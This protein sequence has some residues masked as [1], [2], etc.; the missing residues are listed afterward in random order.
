MISKLYKFTRQCLILF[1]SVFALIITSNNIFG[2]SISGKVICSSDNE[3]IIYASI[4]IIGTSKGTISNENGEF[5]LNVDSICKDSLVRFSMIGFESK[6]FKIKELINKENQI[7]LENKPVQLKEITIKPSGK[8]TKFGTT[9]YSRLG[10]VC[11]WGGTS[12][13]KGHEI[14]TKIELGENMVQLKSLHFRLHK[15]SF[16]SSLFRLHIRDIEQ[17]LPSKE[18]L[19]KEIIISVSEEKGWVDIDLSKYHLTYKGDIALTLEWI[20]VYGTNQD[21]LMKMNGS[22]NYS[23]NVLFNIRKNEKALFIRKGSEAIWHSV[24]NKSPSLYLTAIK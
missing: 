14:G 7:Q 4:G 20:K 19:D 8:A 2:Q 1:V 18:L 15:Q 21:R 17:G 9:N 24:E 5:E 22:K 12:F 16:D 10:G 3:P 13:G 23:A 6:V 11:G